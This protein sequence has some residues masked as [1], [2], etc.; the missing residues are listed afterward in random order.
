MQKECVW[1]FELYTQFNQ[2]LIAPLIGVDVQ[3]RL[4]R[5]K[6]WWFLRL[7]D[8]TVHNESGFSSCNDDVLLE[9]STRHQ[10]QQAEELTRWC[11][12]SRLSVRAVTSCWVFHATLTQIIPTACLSTGIILSSGEIGWF[13]PRLLLDNLFRNLEFSFSCSKDYEGTKETRISDHICRSRHFYINVCT[14]FLY[15]FIP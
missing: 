5:S 10:S 2:W 7:H 3:A 4:D 13:W 9:E 6:P 14:M 12:F 8:G 15:Y 1:N 11:L